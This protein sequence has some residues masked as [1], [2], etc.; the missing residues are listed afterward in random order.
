MDGLFTNGWSWQTPAPDHM[1]P[2]KLDSTCVLPP[3][4]QLTCGRARHACWMLL[5]LGRATPW[6]A[7]GGLSCTPLM[8]WRRLGER[9]WLPPVSQSSRIQC[10]TGSFASLPRKYVRR[11]HSSFR[12]PTLG[13]VA[14]IHLVCGGSVK[15]PATTTYPHGAKVITHDMLTNDRST[16]MTRMHH[17]RACFWGHG[18]TVGRAPP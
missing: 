15:G 18:A 5:S 2:F 9:W 14:P 4:C 16:H 11:I 17:S 3:L 7:G 6:A 13:G 12:L 10:Y 8:D 1:V